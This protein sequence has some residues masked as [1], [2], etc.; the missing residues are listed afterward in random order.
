MLENTDHCTKDLSELQRER[1][2]GLLENKNRIVQKYP[3]QDLE[4]ICEDQ[5]SKTFKLLAYGSLI[6]QESSALTVSVQKKTL[7]KAYGI[8]RIFNYIIPESNSRYGTFDKPKRRAALNIE[9]TNSA[10]DFI[11]ALILEIP[12]SDIPAL[13]ERE[14]AYDL[15]QV[16]CISWENSKL[17]PYYASVLYCPYHYFNGQ[18]KTKNKMEPHTEYYKVCRSGAE[19][20]GEEFLE[21]W[22]TTTFLSDGITSM[23]KWE[24]TIDLLE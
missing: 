5:K 23:S 4:Q 16:P 1:I 24:H 14:I 10:K 15:I 17:E 13:R 11:N 6:N 8:Y 21:C 12:L 22:K 7:V 18:E 9:V 20:F 19:S 2:T 3:W